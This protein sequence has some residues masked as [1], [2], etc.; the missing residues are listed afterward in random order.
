MTA[1]VYDYRQNPQA[2]KRWAKM[3]T[4]Q[5]VIGRINGVPVTAADMP[6]DVNPFDD[7]FDAPY[8]APPQD[9]A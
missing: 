4:N 9:S 2:N 3:D 8:F 6:S 5:E 7:P 1:Q